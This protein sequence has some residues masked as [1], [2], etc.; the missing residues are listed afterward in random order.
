MALHTEGLELHPEFDERVVTEEDHVKLRAFLK[1]MIPSLANDPVVYT[2]RCCYTDTLDGHFWIDNHPMIKGL[3]IGSGGSGHGF[4]MGPVVGK[5][6]ADIAE[7]GTH[8]WSDR[9]KWRNLSSKTEQS[10][11]ARFLQQRKL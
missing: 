3:T 4:K 7:N 2:R 11:E 8:D 9:Y 5:M 6:I 1:A 10:E